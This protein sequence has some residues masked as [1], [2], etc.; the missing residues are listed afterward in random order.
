M[1]ATTKSQRM[2]D[3]AVMISSTMPSTKY[4]CSGSPLILANGSTAIDGLSGSG[5]S[6][7]PHPRVTRASLSR[8]RGRVRE[9]AFRPHPV[10][11]DR[12]GNIL[13]CLVAHIREGEVELARRVLLHP[14]RDADP[15][16]FGQP[17]EL[18]GDIDPVAENVAVL[19]DDIAL[20][21]ADAEF[22]AAV[23]RSLA[24]PLGQCGLYL[25][26]TAQG[27]DDADELDQQPVAGGLDQPAAMLGDLRVDHLGAKRLE[28]T[29]RAVL[30]GL[31]YPAT[32]A[33]RIAARRRSTGC[34]MASPCG[35]DHSRTATA[36]TGE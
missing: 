16:G 12:A 19:G 1:R 24:I 28:P 32:S 29:Q 34:F 2:R 7:A 4:S 5:S 30:V 18:G 3:S 20:V 6:A 26:G 27:I 25:A 9:G 14:R 8:L 21:D 33:T 31:E 10:G 13:Q 22:D 35:A 17:F 11:A 23:C 36:G 15:T